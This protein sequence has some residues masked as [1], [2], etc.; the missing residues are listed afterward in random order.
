MKNKMTISELKQY[1][2]SEAQKLMKAEMLKEERAVI[3]SQLK[4]LNEDEETK[5]YK[6]KVK[7][8]SGSKTIKT[9]GSSMEVAKKKIAN[10]EGCP[11]SAITLVSEGINN[12]SDVFVPQ[13]TYT[14][15]NAGGYEIMLNSAGDAAKVRDAFGSDNPKTSDWL[16][17]KWIANPDIEPGDVVPEDEWNIPVI[18]PEGYNIP[19]NMVMRIHR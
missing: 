8:D 10:A 14:V 1:V 12:E 19:L 5:M 13:G 6:F 18:D 7:H 2:I 9:S 3:I 15:S 16:E 4:K 17:I 11:E